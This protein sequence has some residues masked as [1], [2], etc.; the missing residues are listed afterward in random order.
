MN[1]LN[2]YAVMLNKKSK[3]E[4]RI[5]FKP[6]LIAN[7]ISKKFEDSTYEIQCEFPEQL[8]RGLQILSNFDC[9][10]MIPIGLLMAVDILWKKVNACPE[11]YDFEENE[12][13]DI[14][15]KSGVKGWKAINPNYIE[16]YISGYRLSKKGAFSPK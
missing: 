1:Q 3:R 4:Y 7:I 15:Q 13:Q 9:N 16:R 14:L 5:I 6:H 8:S 10:Q 2:E 12:F 11:N